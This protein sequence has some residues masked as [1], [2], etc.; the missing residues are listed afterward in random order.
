MTNNYT[1]TH[2][3]ISNTHLL[4]SDW[5]WLTHS[6]KSGG[7]KEWLNQLIWKNLFIQTT[8]TNAM[9]LWPSG[10]GIR[11]NYDKTYYLHCLCDSAEK[12]QC[13]AHF[14]DPLENDKTLYE[15][16]IPKEKKPKSAAEAAP[17][18]PGHKSSAPR[19]KK[20]GKKLVNKQKV[21]AA[22]SQVVIRRGGNVE[23]NSVPITVTCSMVT[24]CSYRFSIKI[25]ISYNQNEFDTLILSVTSSPAFN[26]YEVC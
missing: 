25:I 5:P 3:C 21:E 14:A 12:R 2:N 11:A 17:T 24:I 1:Y 6:L 13:N 18:G 4:A 10:F 22:V 15:F 26:G 16:L 23:Y 20:D 19:P 9:S 7:G 8:K